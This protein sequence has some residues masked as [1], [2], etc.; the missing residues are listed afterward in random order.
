MGKALLLI[1]GNGQSAVINRRKW[2]KRWDIRTDRSEHSHLL[3]KLRVAVP[4]VYTYFLRRDGKIF[5]AVLE[6]LR[7]L[8]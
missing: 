2:T 6:I 8:L 3:N 1:G 5:D 7:P 4:D